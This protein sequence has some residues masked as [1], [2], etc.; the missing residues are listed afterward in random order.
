[1]EYTIEV[2]DLRTGKLA[3]PLGFVPGAFSA[4]PEYRLFSSRSVVIATFFGTPAA[5]ALLMALNY[6]RLGRGGRAWMVLLSGLAVSAL[7]VMA[8]MW[9]PRA[10][11]AGL[12]IGL[13]IAT[14]IVAMG[15]Q[16]KPVEQHVAVGGRLASNWMAV[17]IGLGFLAA[18]FAVI[19]AV[20]LTGS[21][22]TKVVIG[23]KDEV[24]YTGKATEAEALALGNALKANGYFQDKGTSVFLNKE[25]QG[26][27]TANST[28]AMNTSISMVVQEGAWDDPAIL[29]KEEE[30]VREAAN[31]VGGLPIHVRVIDANEVVHRQGVVGRSSVDGKDEVLYFGRATAAEAA[32]L[33]RRLGSEEYFTG[34]GASVL[35]NKDDDGT[36]LSFVVGEDTVDDAKVK[37]FE[38]VVRDVAAEAGGLPVRLRLVNA[39]LDVRKEAMVR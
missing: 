18:I 30:V 14:R 12:G 4:S 10:A 22:R 31:T 28:G 9:M 23:T 33:D 32:A 19:F 34:Q 13:L 24:Y 35:L 3:E 37:A 36:T 7:A 6:W 38:D 8:G 16:A 39:G 25:Q 20:V 27:S 29:T 17:A 2:L 15:L 21:T 11:A 26:S 1:M 5:G